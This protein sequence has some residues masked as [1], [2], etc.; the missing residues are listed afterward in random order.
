MPKFRTLYG[1][2]RDESSGRRA[3]NPHPAGC[4]ATDSGRS[5]NGIESACAHL[6]ERLAAALFGDLD[7]HCAIP[8]SGFGLEAPLIE[9]PVLGARQAEVFAQSLAF[10]FAAEEV[11]A[12]EFGDDAV[13]DIVEAARDMREHDV[14]AV[15]GVA[16]EPFLHLVGDHRRGADH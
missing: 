11:A 2:P 9:K 7:R 6:N 16:V 10:V 12:L 14:E 5:F 15:A 8:Q 1:I 13:D 4:L 3:T